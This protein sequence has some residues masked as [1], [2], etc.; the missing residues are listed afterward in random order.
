M[1]PAARARLGLDLARTVD[2]AT[3]MSHPDPVE[4][5]RLMAEAGLTGEEEAE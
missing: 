2:A 1:T 5:E 4:R 3:A